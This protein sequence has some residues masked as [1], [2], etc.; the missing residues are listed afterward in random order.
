MDSEIIGFSEEVRNLR[1]IKS[2]SFVLLIMKTTLK[3]NVGFTSNW[4]MSQ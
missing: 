4:S 3:H 2:D 1:I